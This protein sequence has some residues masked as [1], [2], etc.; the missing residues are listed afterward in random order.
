[1]SGGGVGVEAT[2][3]R[4]WSVCCV[5]QASLDTETVHN[6]FHQCN[7]KVVLARLG[8]C[9]SDAESEEDN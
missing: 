4:W 2:V 1:V 7:I 9:L 5:V 8:D 6:L 3:C